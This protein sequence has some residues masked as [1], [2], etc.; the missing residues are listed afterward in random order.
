[1]GKALER[2][3]GED[4]IGR[5]IICATDQA[6]FDHDRDTF[7]V[8]VPLMTEEGDLIECTPKNFPN[9]GRIWWMLRNEINPLE[10]QPGMICTVVLERA[11][12]HNT[13]QPDKDWFQARRQDVQL[14]SLTYLEMIPLDED[15]DPIGILEQSDLS[16]PY[17]PMN[18]VVLTG[19]NTLLGPLKA[20]WDLISKKLRFTTVNPGY[21]V[22]WRIPGKALPKDA[23]HEFAFHANAY[24]RRTP[25]K[26]IRVALIHEDA[27]QVFEEKGEEHDAA[28]DNQVMNWGLDLFKAA[29]RAE[30]RAVRKALEAIKAG[31]PQTY[32]A[33]RGRM[34]RFL[35]ICS[36]MERLADLNEE[37]AAAMTELDL[38]GVDELLRKH[39]AAVAAERLDEEVRRQY[40]ET[41]KQTSEARERRRRLEEQIESLEETYRRRMKEQEEELN[42]ENEARIHDLEKR[43]QDLVEERARLVHQEEEI[44]KRLEPVLEE[45]RERADSVAKSI[46]V[47]LPILKAVGLGERESQPEAIQSKAQLAFPSFLKSPREHGGLAESAFLDQFAT[48]VR[49]RG[50]TFDRDDL[51]NFHISV[52]TGTWTVLCGPSGTGKSSLPRLYSEALGVANEQ[53]WI[54]VRPDWMDDRDIIGGY[55][56]LSQRFEPAPCGMV[57]RL[58]AAYED[59][60]NKRGGIYLICLDEMNLSRVEHYFAQ[61]LSQM[62]RPQK[63]RCLDLFAR[64]LGQPDD[65]YLPYRRLPIAPAIRFVGTVN[66]DETTHFFSPKVIDRCSLLVLEN[67]DLRGCLTDDQENSAVGGLAPVHADEFTAWLKLPDAA[68][69]ARKL[70]L[71]IN[72]TLI[73]HRCALTPRAFRRFLNYTASAVGLLAPD[74]AF[75]LAFAQ[76]V[77]PRFRTLVPGFLDMLKSLRAVLPDGRFPRS[78]ALLERMIETNGEYDF[79]Q[80]V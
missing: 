43:E 2:L 6:P 33:P 66:I 35:S 47:G 29:T 18:R 20:E 56:A 51:A 30:R 21:P 26:E 70:L 58:I 77:V 52:K 76:I 39:T 75:D 8:L 14:G 49:H 40:A 12:H 5:K 62:A 17:K 72:D 68:G 80:I 67:T 71:E 79:F 59:E 78:A 57:D 41:E 13:S 44:K 37:V 54:A 11:V 50:Y 1:M 16:L 10:V 24:A 25:A 45:Y 42:K 53:L 60:R 23:V 63:D 48:I 34:E 74:R 69:D 19:P 31:S 46:L 55:N 64:G 61:F 73:V 9:R 32:E 65:P 36:S 22:I 27:L 15:P 7:C 4:L 38:E 28:D 3:S